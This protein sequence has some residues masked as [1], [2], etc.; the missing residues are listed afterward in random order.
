MSPSISTCHL[1]LQTTPP[2]IT[3]VSTL[4]GNGKARGV[5][6][7]LQTLDIYGSPALT[8]GGFQLVYGSSGF[9]TSCIPVNVTVLNSSVL[10]A[11]LESANA[12]LN[13]TVNEEE[14][15][16]SDGARRFSLSFMRP[17]LAVEELMVELDGCEEMH[18]DRA[19][20]TECDKSGVI[21]NRDS[22]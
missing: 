20:S 3:K 6:S 18:C 21:V 10:E 7:L 2:S 17:T 1:T 8:S 5:S 12:F 22:S 16:F 9:T 11:A 4:Y 19:N 14:A 15:P 13:V